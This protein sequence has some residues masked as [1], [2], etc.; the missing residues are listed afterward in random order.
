MNKKVEGAA[1][2]S[3]DAQ[4]DARGLDCPMP[5]LKMKLA[6]N[7]LEVGQTV[8]LL[9]TDAGS[10]KDIQS[11]SNMSGHGLLLAQCVDDE[12]HYLIEKSVP[13]RRV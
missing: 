6:L 2:E 10:M 5:L 1:L 12:Y 7:K 8:A 3:A 13:M 11:F 9:A 4:V